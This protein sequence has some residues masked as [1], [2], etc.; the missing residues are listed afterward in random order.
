MRAKRERSNGDTLELERE[1][2]AVYRDAD[3]LYAGWSCPASTDCCH[4]ARTGREPYVTSIELVVMR[5]AVATSS[6]PRG[7]KT[8]P[9]VDRRCR[10]L[11]REGRCSIYA[12]RPLG[13]RTFY[14]DRADE[15]ARVKHQAVNDLVRR[16]KAIAAKHEPGGELGRPLSRCFEDVL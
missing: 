16:V 12:S 7:S 14:C 4:F 6:I 15:G 9:V 2:E 11:T 3:A 10:L 8:L 5:R 13:C 1:L